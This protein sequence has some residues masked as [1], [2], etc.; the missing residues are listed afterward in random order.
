M[1]DYKPQH[2]CKNY[3]MF[4]KELVSTWI[5]AIFTSVFLPFT[6]YCT[7]PLKSL[8]CFPVPCKNLSITKTL[9]HACFFL[10]Q[11]Y[12]QEGSSPSSTFLEVPVKQEMFTG[13]DNRCIHA[14]LFEHVIDF[15]T[16]MLQCMSP[17]IT[18]FGFSKHTCGSSFQC[19]FLRIRVKLF[20]P[21]A[22]CWPSWRALWLNLTSVEKIHSVL[23]HSHIAWDFLCVVFPL[24][25]FYKS[26]LQLLAVH[27]DYLLQITW[28]HWI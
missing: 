28:T 3:Q 11:A 14:S 17:S 27:V 12:R 20:H 22:F 4:L 23:P 7:P 9:P 19:S 6:K 24:C 18:S 21:G 5:D 26:F 1:T 10:T 25:F 15:W 2:D 8:P 13:S 16:H